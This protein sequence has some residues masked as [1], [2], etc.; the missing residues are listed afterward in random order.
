MIQYRSYLKLLSL[1]RVDVLG[2]MHILGDA[3]K[4]SMSALRSMQNLARGVRPKTP[5]TSP[6]PDEQGIPTINTNHGYP[7]RPNK[8][9]H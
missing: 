1:C 4:A 6:V 3:A 7:I 5:V 8:L 2:A 9:V